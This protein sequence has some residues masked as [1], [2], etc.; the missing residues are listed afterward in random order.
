M[1]SSDPA[2]IKDL[3]INQAQASGEHHSNLECGLKSAT[4]CRPKLRLGTKWPSK[5]QVNPLLTVNFGEE[6]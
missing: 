1:I 4:V 5:V 3:N 2:A 6:V